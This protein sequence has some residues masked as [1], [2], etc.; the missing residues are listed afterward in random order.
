MEHLRKDFKAFLESQYKTL[1][2]RSCTEQI[3][4]GFARQQSDVIER[5][6]GMSINKDCIPAIPVIHRSW[7]GVHGLMQMVKNGDKQG[8]VHLNDPLSIKENSRLEVRPDGLYYIYNVQDGTPTLDESC[9]SVETIMQNFRE[10]M[11]GPPYPTLVDETIA[12][13]IHTDVLSKHGVYA[14]GARY[15]VDNVVYIWLNNGRPT[16]DYAYYDYPIENV[17]SPSYDTR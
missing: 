4:K 17:G 9:M 10:R 15:A 2:D 6:M 8:E 16:L 5:L 1:E 14:T 3:I 7:I 11:Y 13:C 12:L